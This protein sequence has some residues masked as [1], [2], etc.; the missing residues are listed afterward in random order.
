MFSH[1][2]EGLFTF[3]VVSKRSRKTNSPSLLIIIK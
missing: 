3:A 1:P 2:G